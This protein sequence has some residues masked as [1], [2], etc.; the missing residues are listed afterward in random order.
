MTY[1]LKYGDQSCIQIE[2]TKQ[3]TADLALKFYYNNLICLVD[4][5]L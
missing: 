2:I 5:L 4:L 1:S 3:L